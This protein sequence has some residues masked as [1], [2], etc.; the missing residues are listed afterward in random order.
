MK[1]LAQ[2][3]ED[4]V[5]KY[6]LVSIIKKD[7]LLY[8]GLFED[9]DDAFDNDDDDEVDRL[10]AEQDKINERMRNSIQAV[11]PIELHVP[12]LKN[13]VATCVDVIWKKI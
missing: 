2:R 13:L 12:M 5:V 4:F 3:I 11:S 7:A 8:I 1:N 10:M 9:I 6:D